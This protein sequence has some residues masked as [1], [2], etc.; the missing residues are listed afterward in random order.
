MKDVRFVVVHAPGPAWKP[1][2]PPFEQPGL[3]GHVE[4][5]RKAL[6]TGKLALGGPFLDPAGGGM[7]IA[8][9]GASEVEIREIAASDPT[10]E[11]GL[12]TFEV[13]QWLI[14]MQA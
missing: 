5:Y 11:S 3:Q 10:V 6:A 14:G 7:M 4:H 12:L 1:G 8:T 13:R 2:V 9:P